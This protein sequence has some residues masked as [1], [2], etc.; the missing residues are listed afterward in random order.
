[1]AFVISLYGWTITYIPEDLLYR[2][3]SP[4]GTFVNYFPRAEMARHFIK[5]NWGDG[6]AK[7]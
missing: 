6:H 5:T 3:N 2:V 4:R 7:T 1:M